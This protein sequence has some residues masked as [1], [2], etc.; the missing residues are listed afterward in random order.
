MKHISINTLLS[1]FITVPIAIV[2]SSCVQGDLYEL[3]DN[4]LLDSKI[5]PKTK[6]HLVDPKPWYEPEEAQVG[7]NQCAVYALMKKFNRTEV[8]DMYYYQEKLCF[9]HC[10]YYNVTTFENICESGGFTPSELVAASDNA[11]TKSS[12]FS[13]L[14]VTIG[15][16]LNFPDNYYIINIPKDGKY[17]FGLAQ[18][19]GQRIIHLFDH[20][21]YVFYDDS[22]DG[23]RIPLDSIQWVLY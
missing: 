3:Y 13:A 15:Q 22:N 20:N 8:T 17:H 12:G 18:R 16:E 5:I 23:G 21:F 1:S 6:Q 9:A 11:L 7:T 2:L 14:G 10:G 4:D 19:Y